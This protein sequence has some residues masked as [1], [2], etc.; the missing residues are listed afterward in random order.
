M[1]Q[2]L[3]SGGTILTMGSSLQA[4]AVLVD[5]GKIKRVGD[6]KELL[7]IADH[8]EEV[9]LEG[10]TM[11]PAFLDAHSHFSACANGL[12]QCS[13]ESARDFHELVDK[14]RT[15]IKENEIPEGSWVMVRD[16]DPE[17][18][19]EKK[20]PDKTVLDQASNRHPIVLQHKSGHVGV[21]NSAGLAWMGIDGNTPD[22]SGGRID[23]RDGEA[24]GYLEENAFIQMQSRIPAVSGENLI[25]AYGKAQEMYAS[26]GITT[27][28][29]G[30][31]PKEM[32]PLYQY[33]GKE[34]KLWLDVVAYPAA[35]DGEEI[36]EALKEHL[37]AYRDGFRLGGYKIFLD[38]SPQSRTAWMR[39]PYLGT[40][41][42]GYPTLT[43]EQVEE[44]VNMALK[45]NRQL[46]AHCNGD[47]AAEQ[48]LRVLEQAAAAGADVAGTR[49]V[50]VHGQLLGL[51]QIPRL[52][53]LGVIPSF[54]VAHVYH[55]GDTHIRNF[56][57]DRA[58]LISPAAA[59][60]EAGIPY[61]FH[62]DAPVIR[63]DMMETVWCAV[64]RITRDG[65]CLGEGQRIPVLEALK[66]VTIRA[67]YQ[68][69]EETGKGSIEEGKQADFVILDRNPLE[70][71]AMELKEVQILQTIKMGKTVYRNQKR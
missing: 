47:A 24:T 32:I 13:V 56:G 52:K 55:W 15:Y 64:N 10:K 5:E 3:I 35:A 34:K 38:G 61:T 48:Y 68:Y 46:L 36:D 6:R 26:Y 40:E 37:N 11:I 23:K 54:F 43:D 4:E 70:V 8:A 44:S 12:L 19:R 14:I 66:A 39:T 41:D 51:D 29:E 9:S 21:L 49:P 71:P 53:K 58:A 16:L 69:G 20:V 33:L 18:L 22:P 59:A 7:A 31:M 50:L 25:Q 60:G 45:K 67:A 65:V 27:I 62:Q 57:Y 42:R 30:M 63:P 28:Q 17:V 2:I 1:A